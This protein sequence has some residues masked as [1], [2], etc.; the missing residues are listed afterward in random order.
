MLRSIALAC[1]ASGLAVAGAFGTQ[2]SARA[3]G[4]TMIVAS[5]G[6]PAYI[7]PTW[8]KGVKAVV[9]DA[10]RTDGW[11]A[12][13]S[14]WP[15]DVN[16]YGYKIDGPADVNRLL[17]ALAAIETELVVLRLCPLKEPTVLGW[18]TRLPEG[19]ATAAIFSLGD[20]ARIDAWYANVRKPFGKL[21]FLDV[22]VAVPPTLTIFVGNATIDLDALEIPERV[23]VEQGCLPGAFHRFN[24]K[25]EKQQD[26][27]A[28]GKPAAERPTPKLDEEAQA[29]AERIEAFLKARCDRPAE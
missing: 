22:P 8:P 6:Q 3:A 12:W 21:D 7:S 10:S 29:V 16:R 19:N 1:A 25:L 18:V 24:T 17:A 27:A 13:F 26:E 2:P 9:N 23:V 11:N 5:P 28:A 14:E 4:G 15:N 20:Q